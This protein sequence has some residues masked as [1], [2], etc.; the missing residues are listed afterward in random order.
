MTVSAE[1]FIRRFLLHALPPGF[2]RIRYY[3][4][5]ANCHRATKLKLCRQLLAA[6]LT[7][8]LPRPHDY[9]DFYAALTAK[10]LRLCPSAGSAPWS[11]SKSWDPDRLRLPSGWIAHDRCPRL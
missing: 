1:E 11:A 9:R 5:M 10:N 4:L 2:P 3:G 6:P 7:D 8:L